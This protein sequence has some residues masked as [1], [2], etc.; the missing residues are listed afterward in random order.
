MTRSLLI[1]G[2]L[3]CS[4]SLLSADDRTGVSQVS[5]YGY[6]DCLKIFNNLTS[7]IIC[8]RV[9]G[10]ILSY[11]HQGHESLPLPKEGEGW[12]YESGKGGGSP[13]PGR[14]DI[15]PE[16]TIP[17]HPELWQGIWQGE[18]IADRHVRVVSPHDKATGVQLVRDYKLDSKT[19]QLECRQTMTNRSKES[20]EYCY[21]SR[22]FAL[23]GGIVVIPLTKPSR[24]PHQYVMYTPAPVINYLPE[25][26]NIR[27]RDGF[28][29]ILGPPAHPK[30]GMDTQ[31]G[32]FAYLMPNDLMF[33]KQYPVYPDRVYNEVAGLTLSIWYPDRPMVELEPI[34]PR[35]KLKP[36]ES[37]SFTETWFLVPQEFPAKGTQVDLKAVESAAKGAMSNK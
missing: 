29:E 9:G 14:F 6:D 30:L 16:T 10:R 34:G 4:T 23:G 25:D 20:V 19:S 2:F 15:G 33:V 22:T 32:W 35:E 18:I 8:P 13:I 28:L 3:L 36:G 11:K 17:K 27:R 26:Q 7:V 5:A 21:W 31:A 37:A 1:I 12:T 24:F